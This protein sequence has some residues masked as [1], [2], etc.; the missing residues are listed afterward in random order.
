LENEGRMLA[1]FMAFYQRLQNNYPHLVIMSHFAPH[2]DHNGS[3]N[4][5]IEEGLK[6]YFQLK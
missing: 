4:P 2:L 5:N 6:L 3:K 1:P